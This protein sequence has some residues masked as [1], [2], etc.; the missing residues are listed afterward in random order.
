[1]SD[2]RKLEQRRREVLCG[3]HDYRQK[4]ET[5]VQRAQACNENSDEKLLEDTRARLATLEEQASQQATTI[6]QL[7]GCLEDAESQRRLAAYLCPARE[8]ADEGTLCMDEMSEWNVPGNVIG[9][10]RATLGGKIA[11]ADKDLDSARSALRALFEERDSWAEY[12]EDYE[13]TM[14]RYA[15][16]LFAGAVVALV[17]AI[18][19]VHFSE[20]FLAGLLLAGLAGSLVSVLAKMPAL[21]VTLSGEL[22]SYGRR[23]LTRLAVGVAASLIGCALLGWG[24]LQ[25][26]IKGQSFSEIMIACTVASDACGKPTIFVMV[27]V[28][29]LFGFTERL[30][31][32]ETKV[33]GK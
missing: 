6:A 19:A 3:I 4:F 25:F 32:V 31:S 23:I 33:L 29:F 7:D 27:A 10:L 18:T 2:R 28:A 9:Q 14:N 12:T 13:G 22:D 17:L 20:I 26:S 5:M 8:V 11:N 30:T 24:V 1:M 16:R 15:K 21:D